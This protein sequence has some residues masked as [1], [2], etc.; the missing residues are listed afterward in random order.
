MRLS[1]SRLLSQFVPLANCIVEGDF[2]PLDEL[3]QRRPH[4]LGQS[5]RR[6]RR[7]TRR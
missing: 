2:S 5:I 6:H 3:L 7:Q 4:G 1:P